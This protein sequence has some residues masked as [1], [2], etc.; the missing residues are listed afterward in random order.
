M[1]GGGGGAGV[2]D[3]SQSSVEIKSFKII[4]YLIINNLKS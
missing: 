2:S 4:A 1:W 3:L